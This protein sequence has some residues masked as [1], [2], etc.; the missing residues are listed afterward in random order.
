MFFYII[1]KNFILYS[2]FMTHLTKNMIIIILDYSIK[3]KFLEANMNW[4]FP[5]HFKVNIDMIFS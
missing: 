5:L 2:I 3:H 4:M 1:Q